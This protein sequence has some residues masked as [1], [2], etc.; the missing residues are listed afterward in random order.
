R[1]HRATTLIARHSYGYDG[2]GNHTQIRDHVNSS[3]LL[4][5]Y[6]Q[7]A[8]PDKLDS[9]RGPG[10]SPHWKF[11]H[12]GAGNV[13]AH[14][15]MNG[16]S[17]ADRYFQYDSASRIVQMTRG[18]RGAVFKY[19][20]A[21]ELIQENT[22][23]G[24]PDDREI[25]HY[26]P[27]FQKR[28]RGTGSAVIERYVPGP[29]GPLASVRGEGATR[30]IV[31]SH[32]D[33]RANKLFT[34]A[35]GTVVQSA[36]Y[37]SYGKIRSQ[38]GTPSSQDYSDDL[39]N[40]GDTYAEF[41]VVVLGARIYD[42]ELGRFLQ[43]D[44]IAYVPRSTKG[45]PYTFSFA[46]P[47]NYADADGLFPYLSI[48]SSAFG[49]SG[50]SGDGGAVGTAIALALSV[51]LGSD[52]SSSPVGSASGAGGFFD[53]V[54]R[55]CAG[56]TGPTRMS[57]DEWAS[58][59]AIGITDSLWTL[60]RETAFNVYDMGGLGMSVWGYETGWY[61]YE[62]ETISEL[63]TAAKQG[64]SSL[65]LLWGMFTSPATSAGGFVE[66]GFDGDPRK[67]GANAMGAYAAFV[68]V[69]GAAGAA[70]GAAAGAAKFVPNPYGRR[71]GPAHR[72]RIAQAESR[73]NAKDYPTISGGI[74][75]G[76]QAV[77]VAGGRTR[78]PDLVIKTPMGD[79]AIQVGRATKSGR[80]VARERRAIDELR[81][82]KRFKHVFF[83]R[84]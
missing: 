41:G 79:V 50:S 57:A 15:R 84:Y 55:A 35:D 82:T 30:S 26:G 83:L 81:A 43:R 77:E 37:H 56:A 66:G 63:A 31:Y 42:P 74:K 60:A 69:R 9:T 68:G 67:M 11:H 32:G 33:G 20:A 21:G 58:E 3:A 4:D 27:S 39:F 54:S 72:A 23:G 5:L 22:Y 34:R 13:V 46:D 45:N 47:I 29:L 36:E 73:L 10:G 17:A 51:A 53:S 40:G 62:H 59:F 64:A 1:T 14:R 19:G 38:T 49:G 61:N 2:L 12:D 78:Y 48:F 6:Y 52:F 8:D 71:G 76:E 70:G 24:G 80:P 18:T 75:R 28:K 7:A 65:D 44:P 25:R 16:S